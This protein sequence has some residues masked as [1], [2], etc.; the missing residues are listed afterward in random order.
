[1]EHLRRNRR[2]RRSYAG[3][4]SEGREARG[5]AAGFSM[6]ELLITLVLLGIVLAIA[7]PSY[8]GWVD[9]S[10]LK[11]AGRM[12]SSDFYDTRARAMAENRA[13]TITY[14]PDPANTYRIQAAA[15]GGLAAVDETKTFGEYGTVRMTSVNGG[16]AAVAVTIQPR[17]SAA[18][19]ATIGIANVRNSTGTITVLMTGRAHV[20]YSMQ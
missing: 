20:T 7:V 10:N 8:R 6:V 14:N 2:K 13:Y 16:G 12:I 4:L 5:G 15:A 3:R 19:A 9:N 18:P 11:G 17:G 1:M